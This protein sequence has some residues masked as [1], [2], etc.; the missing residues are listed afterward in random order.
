MLRA[1]ATSPH[2]SPHTSP[3]LCTP[4]SY[5][6]SVETS[7]QASARAG[8][9]PTEIAKL[10]PG[11]FFGET[12]LLEGRAVRNS[13]VLCETPVEVLMIDNA[14]FQHL[15]ELSDGTSA[16]G[17][18]S[19]L[20]PPGASI[21]SRIRARAEA[22]QRTR[23]N[24]AIEMMNAAPLQQMKV[25]R[26][27]ILYRQG[28]P[29]SHF[30]IV[31]SGKL[32]INFVS[33]NG[34]EA[35]LDTLMPGD[36]FGY[37][38]VVGEFHDTTVRC[39]ETCEV[40]VVPRE[41]LQKAF[42]QDTYLQS[43]WQ[44]PAQRSIRL[45]RQLSQALHT[46]SPQPPA[47]TD[48][49]TDAPKAA[50]GGP[51]LHSALLSRQSSGHSDMRLLDEDFQPLLRRARLCT[52]AEGEPAFVQGSLP[53]GVY[54]MRSGRC[55]VE[56]A[57]TEG[58]MEVVGELSAGD[59]FG[60]GALL[61]GRTKRNCSVRCISP[62]GCGMGVLGKGAFEA[63]LQ[64]QP[65]LADAFERSLA[66]RN[67]QRLR[68]VIQLAAERSECETRTLRAGETLFAQGT[69]ADAF[70]VVE[71]GA[72]QMSY[73]TADGRQL[74]SK[75]HRTGDIFGASGLIGGASTRRDTATAL[76]PTTVKLFPHARFHSLTRQ[77]S[78]LAEGLRRAS[79]QMPTGSGT[80]TAGA[81]RD[82]RGSGPRGYDG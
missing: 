79:T 71:S 81:A 23:L 51:P 4:Y 66:R 7:A 5:L 28:D 48:A 64:T 11:D 63:M 42:T 54:L 32:Q 22:R 69:P 24:R 73:R 59:H 18:S 80:G 41:Q 57:T 25:R 39:L 78:L 60:E 74:P 44:A 43:V 38:A 36:Q 65:H 40:L 82:V 76:E 3:T 9:P 6:P 35:E 34:E 14:M 20:A 1:G 26:G 58:A 31:K 50:A 33:T 49:S 37:D 45:R 2:F 67:R 70:F 10:G 56:H 52:L 55:Q 8:Q 27:E 13:S 62:E 19:P 17:S 75:T 15:T 68:S 47:P 16:A 12:G 29:A 21:A 61:D 77:D 53:T 46:P 30:Y 72:V